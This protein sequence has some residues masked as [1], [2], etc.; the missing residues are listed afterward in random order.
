MVKKILPRYVHVVNN[1]MPAKFQIAKRVSFNYKKN[2]SLYKLW[3]EHAKLMKIFYR[4]KKVVDDEK[5]SI[6]DVEVPEFSLLD[7]KI[8]LTKEIMKS[9]ELCERACKANRLNQ[10]KGNC[11]VIDEPRTASEFMHMGEEPFIS[12]SHTIFFMGCTFHCDYCQNWSISQ[13]NERGTK[14]SAQDLASS[15]ENMREHGSRNVNF[16]GGEP[17]PCLLII[18]E[19]LKL[20]K[21]N[22]PVVWNSNFYMSE[23]T[24]QLLDGIVDMYLSDFKYGNDKCASKL[25]HIENYFKVC[26]RNHRAATKQSELTIRHLLLPNHIE[27]CTRPIIEWIAKNVRKKCIVNMMD[28]YR[29]EYKAVEHNDINRKITKEEFESAVDYAKKFKINYIT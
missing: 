21:I 26:S 3:R 25:S 28:Q 16:V 10:Q 15:I 20:C 6:N 7:L 23:K 19:I 5:L 24:M 12:P 11:G 1:E 4:I 14:V 13:W 8:I 29:P 22:V 2:L 18:L 27:C 17:T 9:C